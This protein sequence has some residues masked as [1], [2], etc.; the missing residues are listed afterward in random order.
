M[1]L[2]QRWHRII[3]ILLMSVWL[4]AGC[5]QNTAETSTYVLEPEEEQVETVPI[6]EDA[7]TALRDTIQEEMRV[8]DVVAHHDAIYALVV[9][10]VS[11]DMDDAAMTEAI[12]VVVSDYMNEQLNRRI[13]GGLSAIEQNYTAEDA[14]WIR[15]TIR[16]ADLYDLIT[17]YEREYYKRNH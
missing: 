11:V 5:A 17:V 15:E 2:K 13:D 14:E 3:G 16:T 4:F 7:L 9:N 10:A 1:I 12:R 6:E 8:F